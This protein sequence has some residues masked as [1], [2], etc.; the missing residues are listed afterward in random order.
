MFCVE[1]KGKI[2]FAASV[3]T[4]VEDQDSRIDIY[5]IYIYEAN[6][7]AEQNKNILKS[8]SF[9][10]RQTLLCWNYKFGLVLILKRVN[11]P[12]KKSTFDTVSWTDIILVI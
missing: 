2:D 1:G 8:N 7:E 10:V 6:T 4:V 3:S 11:R 9:D 12:P 5:W